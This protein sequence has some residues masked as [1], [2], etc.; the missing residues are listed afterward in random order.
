MKNK[1]FIEYILILLLFSPIS[2]FTDDLIYNKEYDKKLKSLNSEELINELLNVNQADIGFHPT[3]WFS[4]FMALENDFEFTGGILGSKKPQ[5]HPA[6]K[7]L[8]KRGMESLPILIKY[9]DDNRETNVIVKRSGMGGTW[10]SDEYHS[11]YLID[12]LKP[13]NINLGKN[14]SIRNDYIL[15]I[16][17]LCFVAIGQIVNRQLNA[18]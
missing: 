12:S 15:K 10:H 16:G 8:V 18:N 2:I 6:L 9:I 1:L 4:G 7:E 17:D 11:R 5:S 3:A 13:K 14:E